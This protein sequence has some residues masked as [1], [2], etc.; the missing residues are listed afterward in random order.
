VHFYTLNRANLTRAVCRLMG[1][2][3]AAPAAA[4]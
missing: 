1:I 4:D 2:G 3:V